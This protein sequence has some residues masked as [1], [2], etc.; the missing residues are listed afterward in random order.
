MIAVTRLDGKAYYINPHQIE[1]IEVRP[2]TTLMMLSGKHHIVREEV[3][4]VLQ[5]I[6]EYYRRIY[7][8]VIQDIEVNRG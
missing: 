4:D 5:K 2:D 6:N 8:P 3:D 1:C 7:P